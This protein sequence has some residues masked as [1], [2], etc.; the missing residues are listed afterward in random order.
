[1]P[2]SG[3]LHAEHAKAR[4]PDGCIQTGRECKRQNPPRIAWANDPVIPKPGGGIVGMA[5]F[6]KLLDDGLFELSLFNL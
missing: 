6:L 2:K 4:I 1:M 5:L 3:L